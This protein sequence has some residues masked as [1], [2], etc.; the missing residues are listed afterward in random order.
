[1]YSENEVVTMAR[2]AYREGRATFELDPKRSALLT[3][4]MQD[5]FVRPGWT[6]Y[7][8]PEA[9]RIVPRVARLIAT[10]RALAIPVIFTAFAQTHHR[11]DRP[12]AGAAMP[13]RYPFESEEW[14]KA[15]R[16]F[17]DLKPQPEDIVI[18][19]PSYGWID[20][21]RIACLGAHYPFLLTPSGSF[22]SFAASSRPLCENSQRC[23]S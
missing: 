3:I 4:D 16:I 12:A 11:L 18:L 21:I 14:F 6:T 23:P 10:C 20:G 9:T 7:W 1:M 22:Q 13:N 2:R 19:K 5:E 15:G 17:D 8:V